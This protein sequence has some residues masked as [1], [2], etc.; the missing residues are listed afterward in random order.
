MPGLTAKETYEKTL[1]EIEVFQ[2]AI[3][4]HTEEGV[5]EGVPWEVHSAVE[6]A[7]ITKLEELQDEAFLY[8]QKHGIRSRDTNTS[9]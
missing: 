9:N 1:S 6:E 2:A 8:E 3:K 4:K 5:P 7:L